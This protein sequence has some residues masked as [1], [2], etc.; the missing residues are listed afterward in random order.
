VHGFRQNTI[1]PDDFRR[2]G[3]RFTGENLDSNL[4][5]AAK[6]SEI[7]QAKGITPAQLALAQADLARIEA[8]LPTVA[9][10]RYGEAGMASLNH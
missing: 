5:L 8:E 9:V 2:H 1:T 4:K 3:P 10:D 6:V 7:A